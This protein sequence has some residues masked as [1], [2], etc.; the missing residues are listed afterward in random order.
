MIYFNAKNHA[1]E[2]LQ[3]VMISAADILQPLMTHGAEILQPLIL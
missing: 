2:T 1:A 3:P